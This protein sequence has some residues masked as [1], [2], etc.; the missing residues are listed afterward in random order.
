MLYV[1]MDDI[2]RSTSACLGM[3]QPVNGT[4]VRRAMV[5]ALSNPKVCTTIEHV[6]I[7]IAVSLEPAHSSGTGSISGLRV[8]PHTT[9]DVCPLTS[10]PLGCPFLA[11]AVRHLSG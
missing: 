1:E 9:R 8:C 11:T 6:Y 10:M 5:K 7:I 2:V 3:T 4:H